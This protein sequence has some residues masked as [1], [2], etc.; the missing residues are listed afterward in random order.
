MNTEDYFDRAW[1]YYIDLKEPMDY[2]FCLEDSDDD[3]FDRGPR[4]ITE[5]DVI[6]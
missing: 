5:F 1:S 2:E 6:K 3:A 4:E